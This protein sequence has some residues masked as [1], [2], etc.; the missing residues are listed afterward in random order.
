MHEVVGTESHTE[1]FP[2]PPGSSDSIPGAKKAGIPK[3]W[4]E[5]DAS[6][7]EATVKAER[8]EASIEEIKEQSIKKVKV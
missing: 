1:S 2:T 3:E 8:T 5:E 6:S 7:S 4:K